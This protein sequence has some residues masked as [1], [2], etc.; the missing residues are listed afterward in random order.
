MDELRVVLVGKTGSGKSALGNTLLGR[1]AFDSERGLNSGTK[2]CNWAEAKVDG[3]ILSVTDTPGLCDTHRKEEEILLEIGKSI[4]VACP[5]PHVVIIVL[6]CDQ[7]FT[8][9][10]H[11]AVKTLLKL[12][13]ENVRSH[14]MAVFVGGDS[15]DVP[16]NQMQAALK[17]EIDKGSELL[18]D[19]VRDVCNRFCVVDNKGS[20]EAKRQHARVVLKI[21]EDVVESNKKRF[22]TN[23]IV[24]KYDKEM[25][26]TISRHQAERNLS[27]EEAVKE[28]RQFVVE[29]KEEPGFFQTLTNVTKDYIL[30]VVSNPLVGKAATL[31]SSQCSVM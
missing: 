24:A 19:V 21:I 17:E 22:F 4:A 8:N 29:E 20:P 12:F 16:F 18:K 3:T 5:G 27:T 10:E 15:L 6:R 23:N 2:K 1:N 26:K 13:G 31:V 7:R 11:Q 30:P 28:T 25:E 9:E 14:L